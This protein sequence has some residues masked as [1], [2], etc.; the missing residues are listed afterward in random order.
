MDYAE[1]L[2]TVRGQKNREN[3]LV[4]KVSYDNKI[5]LPYEDGIKMV[6]GFQKAEKLV[7]GY[8][9][10]HRITGMERDQVTFTTM[11]G[12]EYEQYKMAALLGI[13]VDEIKQAQKDATQGTIK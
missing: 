9:E 13:H 10:T 6:Q 7:D 11:S 4:I 5:V 8:S 2:K 1:A 3:Y 12:E